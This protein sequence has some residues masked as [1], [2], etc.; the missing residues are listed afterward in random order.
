[1]SLHLSLQSNLLTINNACTCTLKGTSFGGLI[2][3]VERNCC[4]AFVTSA[5]ASFAATYGKGNF[6]QVSVPSSPGSS[7]PV[8]ICMTVHTWVVRGTVR[9]KCLVQEY[10]TK[11]LARTEIQTT[12]TR[13]K[14]TNQE[15]ATPPRDARLNS[16]N[17]WPGLSILDV[18]WSVITAEG[19]RNLQLSCL[20]SDHFYLYCL[21]FMLLLK[22]LFTI[23]PS[24]S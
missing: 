21:T 11:H 19:P 6:K 7:L 18:E 10:N 13:D 3:L 9:V 17:C 5:C 12:Q 1:M 22:A 2:S 23:H 8:P 24:L 4:F 20:R 14:C 16:K 15:T